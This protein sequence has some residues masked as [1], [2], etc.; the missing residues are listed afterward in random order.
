[1]FALMD[2]NRQ[3]AQK[4]GSIDSKHFVN[5]RVRVYPEAFGQNLEPL[6]RYTIQFR[7]LLG[8]IRVTPGAKVNDPGGLAAMGHV[9]G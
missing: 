7:G 1:M 5:P 9:W 4:S 6:F 2:T 8:E 3:C